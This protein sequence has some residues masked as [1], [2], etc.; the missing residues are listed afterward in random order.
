MIA[1]KEKQA[2][3]M[4][5]HLVDVLCIMKKLENVIFAIKPMLGKISPKDGVLKCVDSYP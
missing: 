4:T 2:Y 5:C 1:K 3:N